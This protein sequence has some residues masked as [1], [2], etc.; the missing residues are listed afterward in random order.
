MSISTR[1]T[2]NVCRNK[3]QN[4]LSWLSAVEE[5]SRCINTSTCRAFH[6]LSEISLGEGG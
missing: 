5:R 4:S 6:T 3:L 1:L 2:L